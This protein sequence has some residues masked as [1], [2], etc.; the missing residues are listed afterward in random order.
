M[1]SP[2]AEA[3]AA[4]DRTAVTRTLR[5]YEQAVAEAVTDTF[6]ERHPDWVTRYGDRGRVAGI[7]DARFHVQFLTAAIERDSRAAFRDYVQWAAR[8]LAARGI[9]RVFLWENLDQVQQAA[10]PHLTEADGQLLADFIAFATHGD[11]DPSAATTEGPLTLTR[12]LFVQAILTGARTAAL[13]IAREALRHGARIQD[14]Y[15]DVFQDALYDVGR[16][17]ETNVITVAQEHMATAVTQYVMAHVFGTVDAATERRGIAVMTGVPGELHHVGALMVS[18]MLE[19]HGWQVHFLGS[20]LPIPSILS[21]LAD[22]RPQLLGISVT[23]VFNLHHAT[24]LIAA[25]KRAAPGVRVVVGGAACRGDAWRET[26]ADDYASDVR[27][28]IALLCGAVPA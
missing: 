22:T 14:L 10:A 21:T 7:E 25:A 9:D 12:R 26:G 16:L 6:L 4:P 24:R 11:A 8:V 1:E 2:R 27:S 19:A 5:R 3:I 18:D 13:T 28:A 23:M 17:W 15:A 20:N